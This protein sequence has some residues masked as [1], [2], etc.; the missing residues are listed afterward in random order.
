VVSAKTALILLVR[1]KIVKDL[2]YVFVRWER[3]NNKATFDWEEPTKM[4]KGLSPLG[5]SLLEAISKQQIRAVLLLT[6][7]PKMAF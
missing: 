1:H 7:V 3:G 5:F 6:K 2:T 4:D